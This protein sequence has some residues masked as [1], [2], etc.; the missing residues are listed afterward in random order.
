MSTVTATLS[1]AS[2]VP[3]AVTVSAEP[4][5]PATAADFTLSGETLTFP[6][7]DKTSTGT[8]TLTAENNDLDTPDKTVTV[9]GEVEIYGLGH[10]CAMPRRR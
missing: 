1:H 6:A 3:I 9:K 5:A 10:D 4:T 2:S 8:V 7:G